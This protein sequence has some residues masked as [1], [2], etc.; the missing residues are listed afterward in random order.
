[1]SDSIGNRFG[2]I[3]VREGLA[4]ESA[5]RDCLAIQDKLRAFGVEPKKI[6]E[7]LVEK[8]FLQEPDVQTVLTLQREASQPAAP[9]PSRE[10]APPKTSTV[11]VHDDFVPPKQL[12]GYEILELLGAGGMGAV[13]KARQTSLDRTVAIKILPPRVAKNRSFIQRFISEARTVARLNH[14]NIIA[15]I[16]VG[17]DQGFYYFVM[18]YVEGE[19]LDKLIEREGRLQEDTALEIM[20]QMARALDHASKNNLIHRDIK[21]QNILMDTQGQAKL[22]D[23]G[24][25]QT[26]SELAPANTASGETRGALLGTPHY[27]SPEQARDESDLDIRSDL[28]SLGA[29]FFHMVVGRPP[30]EGK[31]PMVLMTKHLT[32]EPPVPHKLNNALSKSSSELILALLEKNKEDRPQTAAELLEDLERLKRGEKIKIGSAGSR[33]VRRAERRVGKSGESSRRRRS[34]RGPGT[35]SSYVDEGKRRRRAAA[36]RSAKQTESNFLLIFGVTVALLLSIFVFTIYLDPSSSLGPPAKK[37]DPAF[38]QEARAAYTS[39]RQS[40]IAGDLQAA[41]RGY[42]LVV[43]KYSGTAIASNAKDRLDQLR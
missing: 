43:S 37:V 17:D 10:T 42:Q 26:I 18:E 8:G 23:L 33:R 7:I 5:I 11:G 19:S 21:P 25:A 41:K 13:Y 28:Y 9:A 30:F 15:G 27:L 20:I 2:E 22:C 36:I 6:G 3:V 1:L 4:S 34:D 29:T 39:A 40:E 16:D 38:E 14:K 12:A 24:L 31:S 32:E 35:N